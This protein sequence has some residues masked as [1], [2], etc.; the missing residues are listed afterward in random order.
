MI[1][2][3]DNQLLRPILP[4]KLKQKIHTISTSWTG[5]NYLVF[6]SKTILRKYFLDHILDSLY[7]FLIQFLNKCKKVIIRSYFIQNT[8]LA[9]HTFMLYHIPLVFTIVY[10][11]GHHLPQTERSPISWTGTIYMLGTQ[12]K[13]TMISRWALR[14]HRNQLMTPFTLKWFIMHSKRHIYTGEVLLK[15]RANLARKWIN[16]DSLKGWFFIRSERDT[17]ELLSTI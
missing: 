11:D 16:F 13:R 14:M 7:S 9:T 8:L 1:K 12:A 6:R 5:N 17:T 4:R 2:M 10:I 3:S 15:R